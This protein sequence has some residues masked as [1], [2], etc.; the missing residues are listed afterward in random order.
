MYKKIKEYFEKKYTLRYFE[1]K[2][3]III[4][5]LSTLFLVNV[6]PRF[7]N[8][9]LE[10]PWYGYVI[11]IAILAI[12]WIIWRNHASNKQVSKEQHRH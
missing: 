12:I 6:W 5:L 2:S 9:V 10:F 7:R 4:T 8:D 3:M 11:L 1:I